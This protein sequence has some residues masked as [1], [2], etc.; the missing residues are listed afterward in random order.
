MNISN[1]S[2]KVT[3]G[4]L[5]LNLYL[6]GVDLPSIQQKGRTL[7]VEGI[8]DNYNVR[9]HYTFTLH[10]DCRDTVRHTYHQGLLNIICDNINSLDTNLVTIS[11]HDCVKAL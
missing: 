11:H 10:P 5:T 7:T 4:I 6:P 3:N 2:W 9:Y 1:S 8:N